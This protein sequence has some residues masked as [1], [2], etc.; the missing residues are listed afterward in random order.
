[1]SAGL[2]DADASNERLVREHLLQNRA[3]NAKFRGLKHVFDRRS[4]RRY[5][6]RV[7]V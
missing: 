5:G 3:S 2:A 7:F 1:M 4:G 6:R